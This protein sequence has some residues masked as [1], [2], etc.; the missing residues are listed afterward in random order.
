MLAED[1][2]RRAAVERVDRVE[3]LE[4][5]RV[6]GLDDLARDHSLRQQ[7]LVERRGDDVAVGGADVLLVG[8]H[9]DAGVR[10]QGPRGR[11]P[12]DRSGVP[13]DAETDL[14]LLA[15]FEGDEDGVGLL[16]LVLD[17]RFGER[18]AL[19]PAP[20]DRLGAL[21]QQPLVRH[22]A[23]GAV[24]V[25]LEPVIH[26][27]VGVLPVGDDA[28]LLELVALDGDELRGVLAAE[29]THL[30]RGELF[31]FL[32]AAEFLLD[33]LL[34]R[35]AVAVP[36][37]R[38]ADGLAVEVVMLDDDVFQN[39]VERVADV[40]VA[41]GVRRAVVQREGFRALAVLLHLFVDLRLIPG[42]ITLRLVLHQVPPHRELRFR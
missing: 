32:L 21:D 36:A 15:Q 41:V 27:Q 30:R 18:R 35:Q 28:E 17:L 25:R 10:R 29:L 9:R 13:L 20:V 40:G 2:L 14:R 6:E 34:D 39:L 19:R 5:L 42:R 31:L 11:R 22:V 26:R 12:D 7:R 23:E 37:R 24:D 3:L 33:L 38:E 8:I 4:L 16:L 1:D